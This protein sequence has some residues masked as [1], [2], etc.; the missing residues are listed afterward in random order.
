MHCY[1]SGGCG[2]YEN[3]A[4]NECPASKPNYNTAMQNQEAPTRVKIRLDTQTDV[5]NFVSTVIGLPF[6]VTVTDNNGLRVNAKS[7]LGMLY[8]LEFEELWCECQFDIYEIIKDFVI[9]E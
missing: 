9:N 3:K 8:S 7:L 6:S 1:R 5:N 2:P 4:C